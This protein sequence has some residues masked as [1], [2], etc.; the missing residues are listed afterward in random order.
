LKRAGVPHNVLNAK[1]H[2]REAE[3]VAQAGRKGS[4]T[5]ATNMAG[6]GTDILLGGNPEY[7]AKHGLGDKLDGLP[8]EEQEK[9]LAA[10]VA[11]LKISCAKEREEVMAAGG[12]FIVGTERHESRRIDNQLRGRAGRQGDPGASR[13][14]LSLQDDL[15]RIFGSVNVAKY[16]EDGVPIEHKWVTRAIENA[17]K[18]VEAH[19]FDIRKHLLEY[20]DVMNQQRKVIYSM[21]REILSGE[22]LKDVL[23]GMVDDVASGIA[24]EFYP[25][26]KKSDE[27]WDVNGLNAALMNAFHL[28]GTFSIDEL[29]PIST[30]GELVKAIVAKVEKAY[31]QKEKA[32]GPAIMTDFVQMVLL[33]TIDQCW[34]DHLLAMD[35]LREGIGLRGYAQKDPLLEYKKEGFRYFELMYLQINNDSTR[36]VFEVEIQREEQ[37]QQMAPRAPTNIVM[38]HGELPAEGTAP[39][40]TAR[41]GA[42]P[43]GGSGRVTVSGAGGAMLES[44]VGRNDPCPC[45]SGK[46]YKKCHG[47]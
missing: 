42:A 21:R 15:M 45:G 23:L 18:K 29:R 46:K 32:V 34:K 38:S 36:R 41:G 37:I 3:I 30:E 24:L 19:N 33:S 39:A 20:D 22:N 27:T 31:D 40:P 14:Y 4:V 5:I 1:N 16:M 17:Q 26:K 47:T 44:K 7:M 35:H 9:M 43:S 11:K 8:P 2:A 28:N 13:F 10:E 25:G 6:R 12:L